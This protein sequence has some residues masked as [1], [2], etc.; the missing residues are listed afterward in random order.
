MLVG[1]V[2][3]ACVRACVRADRGGIVLGVEAASA[4][5]AHGGRDDADAGASFAGDEAAAAVA[6]ALGGCGAGGAGDEAAAALLAVSDGAA[7]RDCGRR[8]AELAS[9]AR[10]VCG[11]GGRE[12]G[13]ELLAQ[14]RHRGIGARA[15][16]K[17][18]VL[19]RE[20][21]E[22]S[23]AL[24]LCYAL[25]LLGEESDERLRVARVTRVVTRERARERERDIETET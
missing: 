6:L 13:V 19:R 22:R 12:R 5:G 21:L 16:A 14:T 2:A 7:E 8:G 9:C 4:I 11:G 15:C 24:V 20:S 18:V 17:V 3:C 1:H 25:P 10:G 23:V